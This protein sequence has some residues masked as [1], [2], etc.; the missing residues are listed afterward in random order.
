MTIDPLKYRTIFL[1]EA[2]DQLA[3]YEQALLSLDP[4]HYDT[5]AVDTAYRAVHSLKAGA[6]A[7]GLEEIAK[8]SHCLERLLDRARDVKTTSAGDLDHLLAGFDVLTAYVRAANDPTFQG[9]D[10]QKVLADLDD[11][12]APKPAPKASPTPKPSGW[13]APSRPCRP[14]AARSASSSV[15]SCSRA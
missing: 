11:K 7:V 5:E 12:P 13:R 2:Q 6:D 4:A 15:P 1:Q 14:A 9:P 8:Y 10:L 3:S